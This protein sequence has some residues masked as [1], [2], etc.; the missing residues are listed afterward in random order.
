MR[1]LS[2][3]ITSLSLNFVAGRNDKACPELSN[4]CKCRCTSCK[5][6]ML[7]CDEHT[8]CSPANRASSGVE[9]PDEAVAP[10]RAPPA[11]DVRLM[12]Q[13]VASAAQAP[14]SPLL[15]D[16][17]SEDT[18]DEPIS[19]T[20]IVGSAAEADSG[21]HQAVQQSSSASSKRLD[22]DQAVA[23]LSDADSAPPPEQLPAA[24]VPEPAALSTPPR[25][26][27]HCGLG[28]GALAAMQCPT[29][30][31]TCRAL[32]RG[33][34]PDARCTGTECSYCLLAQV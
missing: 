22:G 30:P 32:S 28:A 6:V 27:A 31:R 3:L 29:P 10:A 4:A 1:A 21:A 20:A 5:L 25:R 26:T 13:N 16:E 12:P 19:P 15:A 2:T 11:P 9:R 14:A 34:R 8:V 23:E 18:L 7:D 17:T 33:L 24:L